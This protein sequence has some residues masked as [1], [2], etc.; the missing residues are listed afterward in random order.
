MTG[1]SP[2]PSIYVSRDWLRALEADTES[3]ASV[4]VDDY[5]IPV[6][7][8]VVEAPVLTYGEYMRQAEAER[9]ARAAQRAAAGLQTTPR[10]LLGL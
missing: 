9:D 3:G 1:Q 5:L 7:D 10:W 8:S 4:N 2:A 6:P